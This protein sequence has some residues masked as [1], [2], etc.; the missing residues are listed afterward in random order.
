MW[1]TLDRGETFLKTKL[2][3]EPNKL[4]LKLLDFHPKHKD[5]LLFMASTSCPGCHS[6]TYFSADNGKN[7]KEIETWAEK[8]IFGVDTDF[9]GTDDDA[10]FC[11]SYKNKNSKISQDELG[12][13]TSEANP[14]QLFKLKTDGDQKKKKTLLD[15]VI[16]FFIFDE[17]MAAATVCFVFQFHKLF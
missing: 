7:W 14:L 4:N 9:S 5:W 8:C 10:V 12:G 3:K 6:I 1:Y 2:E 15:D 11:S 13:R 17:F 16:N